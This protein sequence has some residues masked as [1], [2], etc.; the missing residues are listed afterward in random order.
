M[1]LSSSIRKWHKWLALFLGIQTLI[2]LFS[3]VYMVSVDLDYIHGDQLV[4]KMDQPLNSDYSTLISFGEIQNKY[5]SSNHIQLVQWLDQPHYRVSENGASYLLD[6]VSG[7]V[8]SPLSKQ[9]AQR[10]AE[11]HFAQQGNIIGVTLLTD[12]KTAPSELYGRPLPLWQIR[13]DDPIASN[14]YISPDDGRLVT[15]RHELWRIFDF[16]W[17]LH[18]MDYENRTDV[19]NLLLIISAILGT[20]LSLA[21]FWLLFYSFKKRKFRKGISK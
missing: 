7:K 15:R 5:P 11:Y 12:Q 21:G 10:V 13:F 6:A 17:M 1:R 14:F 18:I 16:L 19:N 8:I 2:W 20:L 3:G 9:D 4:Q